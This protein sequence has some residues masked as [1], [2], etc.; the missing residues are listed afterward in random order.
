MMLRRVVS[1]ACMAAGLTILGQ[2]AESRVN[3]Q[4]CEPDGPYYPYRCNPAHQ[5]PPGNPQIHTHGCHSSHYFWCVSDDGS[6]CGSDRGFG[7]VYP[8]ECEGY[9]TEYGLTQ[10]VKDASATGIVMRYHENSCEFFDGSCQCVWMY[11]KYP[12]MIIP[13]CDCEESPF[14]RESVY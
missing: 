5:V 11:D 7:H 6:L 10:C 1:L 14:D 13:T 8:G 4:F 2:Q 3:A 12:P 9:I